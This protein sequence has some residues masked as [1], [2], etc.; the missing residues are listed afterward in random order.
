MTYNF[1]K[2][3]FKNLLITLPFIISTELILGNW[4]SKP[5]VASLPSAIFSEEINFKL[6][7]K[8]LD[9]QP[10]IL[11]KYTRDK[12]GYRGWN[13]ENNYFKNP[14]KFILVIGD[15]TTDQ[16]YESD[17]FTWTER[18]E[19][20]LHKKGLNDIDV[21]NA[22]IDGHTTYGYLKAI[23]N[24]HSQDLNEIKPFI[25]SIIFTI[26]IQETK[27]FIKQENG[28]YRKI[29]DSEQKLSKKI[30]NILRTN[31]FF[32]KIL[33]NIKK[34]YII[35]N[36]LKL[37]LVNNKRLRSWKFDDYYQE[38]NYEIN[39]NANQVENY[40]NH[41]RKLLL[42]TKS[43]FPES[44]IIINQQYMPACDFSSNKYIIQRIPQD[45][46]RIYTN[47]FCKIMKKIFENQEK[48]ILNLNKIKQKNIYIYKM[49]LKEKISDN[50]YYDFAH[51]VGIGSEEIGSAFANYYFNLNK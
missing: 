1:I 32:Y 39:L 9:Y 41:F 5:N 23:Q 28:Q 29:S 44:K 37:Y 51:P 22:G 24:W 13:S 25:E 27:Y 35:K 18:M 2:R 30:K 38:T 26:G 47:D 21:I 4:L 42:T 46:K 17:K 50:G 19:K 45:L 49:Y 3:I 40:N 48:L 7:E 31:S 15:S 6:T 14:K 20:V 36:K 10:R 8:W 43:F 16:R 33:R 12:L 34:D 11:I